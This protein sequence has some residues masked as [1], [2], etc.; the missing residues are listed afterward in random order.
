MTGD[1]ERWLPI[2]L[3]FEGGWYP[4]GPGDPNPTMYGVIQSEYDRFRNTLPAPRQSVQLITTGEV[5]FIYR[6]EYWDI[7]KCDGLAW[8]LC[9]VVADVAVNNGVG[10]AKQ[11]LKKTKDA[12]TMLDLRDHFYR[13][14]A[15]RRPE[16]SR[17]LAGWLK[18][19]AALRRLLEAA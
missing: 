7:L 16:T 6:T 12:A 17:F 19:D 13:D 3:H 15:A 10:R 1:F 2:L 4:G 18:R 9:A 5:T 8:P 11:W 14:L